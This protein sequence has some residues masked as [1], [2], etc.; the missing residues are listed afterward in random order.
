MNETTIRQW[1]NVVLENGT[2]VRW[3]GRC[4]IIRSGLSGRIVSKHDS[5]DYAMAKARRIDTPKTP[6]GGGQ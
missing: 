2:A 4:W 6:S 3:T 1:N 5:R